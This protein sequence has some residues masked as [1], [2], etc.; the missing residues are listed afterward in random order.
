MLAPTGKAHEARCAFSFAFALWA[1]SRKALVAV[2]DPALHDIAGSVFWVL[3]TAESCSA[4]AAPVSF[5]SPMR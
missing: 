3:A 4:G 1:L 2:A 5:A